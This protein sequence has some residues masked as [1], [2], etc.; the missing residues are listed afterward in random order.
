MKLKANFSFTLINESEH[1]TD[2]AAMLFFIRKSPIQ[3]N[4][5]EITQHTAKKN[6]D[7]EFKEEIIQLDSQDTL[8]YDIENLYFGYSVTDI[9]YIHF[10][11]F[12]KSI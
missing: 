6:V 1:I 2:I 7:E 9:F 4:Y 10:V 3:R 5:K 11:V 8:S 12:Y